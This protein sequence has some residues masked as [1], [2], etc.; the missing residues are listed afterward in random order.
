MPAGGVGRILPDLGGTEDNGRSIFSVEAKTNSAFAPLTKTTIAMIKGD[1]KL[2]YYKG[3]DGYDD[4]F[5]LY[6]LSEDIE[7]MQNLI[8]KIHPIWQV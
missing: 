4:V 2:I 1:Y 6:N 8:P 5:E 7:E 3:Y